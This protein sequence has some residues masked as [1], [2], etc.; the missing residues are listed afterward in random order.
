MRAHVMGKKE[1]RLRTRERD[2]RVERLTG[3]PTSAN[4]NGWGTVVRVE[5]RKYS[6]FKTKI[7]IRFNLN[8]NYHFVPGMR[9]MGVGGVLQNVSFEGLSIDSRL[10]LIDVCQLFPEALEDNS[11]FELEVLLTDSKDRRFVIRG[12]VIWYRIGEPERDVRAFQAGL[13]LKDSESRAVARSIVKS[14]NKRAKD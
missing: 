9:R 8:P 5:N 14:I 3:N 7:P 11:P 12:S 13:H 6:R 2:S 4:K 10:D 1:K